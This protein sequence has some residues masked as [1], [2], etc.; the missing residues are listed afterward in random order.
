MTL[1]PDRAHVAD[2]QNSALHVLQ[3]RSLRPGSPDPPMAAPMCGQLH[4]PRQQVLCHLRTT[5]HS[6]IHLCNSSG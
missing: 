4:V 5:W 2:A 1:S 6:W 3:C